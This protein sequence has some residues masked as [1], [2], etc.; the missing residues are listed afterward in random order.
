M[1]KFQVFKFYK[2]RPFTSYEFYA[3]IQQLKGKKIAPKTEPGKNRYPN[4]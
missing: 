4:L 3:K 2:G 1:N